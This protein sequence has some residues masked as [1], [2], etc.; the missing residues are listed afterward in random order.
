MSA[1]SDKIQYDGMLNKINPFDILEQL[2]AQK[3][4]CY[5]WVDYKTTC[6]K[7]TV[8]SFQRVN[9][10]LLNKWEYTVGQSTCYPYILRIHI[11]NFTCNTWPKYNPNKPQL[12]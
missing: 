7:H 8:G 2:F 12:N 4:T 11:I 6:G 1:Y 9:K 5:V 10:K 3:D